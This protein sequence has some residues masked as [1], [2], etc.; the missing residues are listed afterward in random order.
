MPRRTRDYEAT[1]IRRL[2]DRDYA[3]RYLN[4][5]LSDADE[6]SAGEFLT[7]LR[8]LAKAR[9]LP[10]SQLAEDAGL[11]RPSLYRALSEDGNPELSTLTS[12]LRELGLRLKVD[13]AA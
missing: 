1:L 4:A 3:V 6:G 5:V 9:G 10:M 11:G 13:N 7:A 2:S 12:V 8:M